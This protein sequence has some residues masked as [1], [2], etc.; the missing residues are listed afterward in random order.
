MYSPPT[1]FS[2][3]CHLQTSVQDSHFELSILEVAQCGSEIIFVPQLHFKI[4]QYSA[5][6]QS[7]SISHCSIQVSKMVDFLRFVEKV[8]FN[9]SRSEETHLIKRS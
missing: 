4:A 6:K 3:N 5:W 1:F 8:Y 2:V 9:A 7:A